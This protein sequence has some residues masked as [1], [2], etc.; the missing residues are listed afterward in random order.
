MPKHWPT[1]AQKEQWGRMEDAQPEVERECDGLSGKAK[2]A[3]R[4]RV[5]SELM[6]K[7]D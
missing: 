7:D 3:C 4:A 1:E 2:M 5:L 6:E